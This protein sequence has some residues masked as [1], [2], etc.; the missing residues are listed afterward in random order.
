MTTL[1]SYA[2]APACVR[3]LVGT[4][5][6]AKHR[7]DASIALLYQHKALARKD[8]TI[9]GLD[10]QS[11]YDLLC[12]LEDLQDRMKRLER[13]TFPEPKK[14]ASKTNIDPSSVPVVETLL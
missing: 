2:T 1:I 4:Y 9:A 5:R 10:Y 12:L 6:Y 14:G 7:I 8:V 11:T 3:E 13:L